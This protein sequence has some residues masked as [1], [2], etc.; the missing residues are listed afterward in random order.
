MSSVSMDFKLCSNPN[1]LSSDMS[2][3]FLFLSAYQ[4]AW[5]LA[6]MAF[7]VPFRVCMYWDDDISKSTGTFWFELFT[8]ITF[9]LDIMMNFV[10]AYQDPTSKCMVCNPKRIAVRYLKG[11]F[12]FDFVATIP[13]NYILSSSN[14]NLVANKLGK[15]G[16]LPRMVRFL[17]AVR[18][19][20][21]LR[22]YKVSIIIPF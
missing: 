13:F 14:G 20:K 8:D 5:L 17:K 1:M 9:A 6:S 21:L 19:L 10:T 3:C 12:F 11:Y 4:V 16:R 22:V 15:L 18:L 2:L 7:Y